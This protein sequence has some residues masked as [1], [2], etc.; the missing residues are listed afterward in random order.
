MNKVQMNKPRL[1][2][3]LTKNNIEHKAINIYWW[4]LSKEGFAP[5]D[6]MYEGH[7]PSIC[8]NKER[9]YVTF[10]QMLTLIDKHFKPV[11]K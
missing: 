10:D 8:F 9:H 3:F 2:S 1:E 7:N 6:V 11:K 5:I 4:A